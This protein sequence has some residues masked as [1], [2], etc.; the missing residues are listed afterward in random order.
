MWRV[1][2]AAII[3][4]PVIGTGPAS[5]EYAWFTHAQSP[6]SAGGSNDVERDP[7]SLPLFLASTL[8]LPSALIGLLLFGFT[9]IAASRMGFRRIR[10]DPAEFG[11]GHHAAWT[12]AT[13]GLGVATTVAAV[14]TPILALFVVALA[15]LARTSC[16]TRATA[17]VGSQRITVLVLAVALSI[18]SLPPLALQLVAEQAVAGTAHTA[19]FTRADRWSAWVPWDID[20]QKAYFRMRALRVENDYK[21][22]APDAAQR[23]ER[24]KADLDSAASEYPRELYYPAVKAQ[25]FTNVGVVSRDRGHAEA[26][27]AAAD[28]ALMIMPASIPVRINR[29]LALSYL[30]RYEEMAATLSGW[31]MNERSSS[32]PGVLYAQAL[33][34]SGDAEGCWKVFDRVMAMFPN[35]A[36][37]PATR[38]HIE[39][40]LVE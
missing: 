26:A 34:L 28:A 31:W 19:D 36:S 33:A 11:V 7:H 32:Y 25:V 10:R 6:S 38:T 16:A 9:L 37:L 13:A 22:G 39:N 29:A 2:T 40:L 21:N 14:T 15:V 27:I 4:R 35:D 23:L 18:M 30:E 5:F 17:L 8:G 3:D 24:L 20:V 12:A 1:A